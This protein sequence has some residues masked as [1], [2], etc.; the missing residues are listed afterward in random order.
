LVLPIIRV[1]GQGVRELLR[2]GRA[3]AVGVVGVEELVIFEEAV[4]GLVAVE[5]ET[6][7]REES[8]RLPLTA[9]RY[10]AVCVLSTLKLSTIVS[11]ASAS[12]TYV[13]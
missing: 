8:S 13:S 5:L 9:R 11:G 12:R 2:L 3:V 10:Q 1:G 7:S 4:G 6:F